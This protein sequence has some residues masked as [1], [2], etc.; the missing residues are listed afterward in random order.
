M[1]LNKEQREDLGRMRGLVFPI[2][3]AAVVLF[4]TLVVWTNTCQGQEMMSDNYVFP[5]VA[6]ARGEAG[7]V[8]Q[9][10]LC[11]SNPH[12]YPLKVNVQMWQDGAMF[13]A[14][15]M[16]P[17]DGSVCSED[18]LGEWFN[19]QRYHGGLVL[20]STASENPELEYV[21]F[22][23]EVRVYNLTDHGT[24]GTLVDPYP[25]Y[26]LGDPRGFVYPWGQVSG[27]IHRGE[28]GEDGFRVSVGA[29]NFDENPR[30]IEYWLRERNGNVAWQH[31]L[32]VPGRSQVQ[33]AIP[34]EVEMS[35]WGSV[36]MQDPLWRDGDRPPLYGY[37]TVTDNQ[38]GDGAYK[39]V[40]SPYEWQIEE[41]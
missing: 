19:T 31:W 14:G 41:D 16:V 9:T 11:I 37:V 3:I 35:T 17:S 36:T 40:A 25:R 18:F 5:V 39:P 23:A 38:T 8:W 26:P 12:W 33:E 29:F 30:T 32:E 6:R 13:G 27:V 4:L 7:T 28:P 10:Q 15:V 24:Y 22:T 21:V 34:G 20:Y 2:I 1:T